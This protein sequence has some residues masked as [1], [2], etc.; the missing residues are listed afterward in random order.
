MKDLDIFLSKQIDL[1][2]QSR[3]RTTNCLRTKAPRGAPWKTRK[4]D[5]S[6]GSSTTP[7]TSYVKSKPSLG[8][9]RGIPEESD[10]TFPE[11]LVRFVRDG[12]AA[13]PEREILD[14]MNDL[15]NK[16]R[17]L[18]SLGLLDSESGL[19]DL[20]E[21]DVLRAR[22]ALTIYVGDIEQKLNVFDDMASR[23][24]L[25]VDII[26]G[27][28]KYKKLTIDR[29]HGFRVISDV[30]QTIRLQDL[31]SGEQH[32]LVLLYELLFKGPRNGLVL[33]DEPEI[34]LHVGWQSQFRPI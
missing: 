13:L 10:R 23:I 34:S 27:R 11:R 9:M 30:G 26:N 20:S 8:T 21:E 29:E 24:G 17:R 15:E 28:F 1:V 14:R 6:Q 16:R 2:L 25:L 22:E 31:S 32:E 12:Q 5:R 18:I 19:R 4:K 3:S 7:G 33:V